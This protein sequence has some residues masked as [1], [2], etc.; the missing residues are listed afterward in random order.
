MSFFTLSQIVRQSARA[1]LISKRQPRATG[2][3]LPTTTTSLLSNWLLRNAR[4]SCAPTTSTRCTNG[5]ETS[6]HSYDPVANASRGLRSATQC[7][8][9]VVA[10]T[11]CAAVHTHAYARGVWHRVCM[12][13]SMHP[14]AKYTEDFS[15]SRSTR[16]A[17]QS[18]IMPK[19]AVYSRKGGSKNAGRSTLPGKIDTLC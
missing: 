12:C 5:W 4:G 16:T 9:T 8:R 7:R 17:P 19:P 1:S 6:I 3:P 10:L 15:A 18:A 2:L 13:T 14:A 11:R